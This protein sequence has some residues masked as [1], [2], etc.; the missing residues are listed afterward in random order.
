MF[1]ENSEELNYNNND[2][3]NWWGGF[4]KRTKQVF[5]CA[6]KKWLT[7]TVYFNL[8]GRLEK[9]NSSFNVEMNP[10]NSI[11]TCPESL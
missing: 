7:R 4:M 8:T 5:R 1:K 2:A 6:W 10:I 9:S 11:R 3:V